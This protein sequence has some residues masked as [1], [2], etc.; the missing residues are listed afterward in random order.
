MTALLGVVF[1]FGGMEVIGMAAAESH[2]PG[3][4]IRSAV[5]TAIWRIALF[6]LGSVL[7]LVLLL[8]WGQRVRTRARTS[9]RSCASASPT[10]TWSPRR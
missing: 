7:V 10:R 1:A 4:S 6:Y 3:R 2:D 8:P 9:P 5:R